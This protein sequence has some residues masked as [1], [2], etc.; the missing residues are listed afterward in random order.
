MG[1]RNLLATSFMGLFKIN[2]LNLRVLMMKPKIKLII[3]KPD[4]VRANVFQTIP[5]EL[6]CLL[7]QWNFSVIKQL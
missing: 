2:V 4:S 3:Q 1:H 6:L 7:L 5:V